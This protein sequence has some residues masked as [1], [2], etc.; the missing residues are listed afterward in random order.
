MKHDVGPLPLL[1]LL[2]GTAC[3]TPDPGPYQLRFDEIG[4]WPHDRG[5]PRHHPPALRKLIGQQVTLEGF[6][7]PIEGAEEMR[8]FYLVRDLFTQKPDSP[9]RSTSPVHVFLAEGHATGHE[10]GRVRV[11]GR[12]HLG[13]LQYSEIT[14][15]VCQIHDATLEVLSKER[16]K[17]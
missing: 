6:V 8:E 1:L 5:G 11:S 13:L 4:P 7:S 9:A 17:R 10:N 16:S 15:E 12:F 3:A 14:V 2:L